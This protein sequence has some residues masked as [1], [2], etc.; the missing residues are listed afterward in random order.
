[1][2]APSA[3]QERVFRKRGAPA[4]FVPEPV[5]YR[6]A[7]RAK[8]LVDE[9]SAV[10]SKLVRRDEHSWLYEP[11]D[12]AR[13]ELYAPTQLAA[14]AAVVPPPLHF[15]TL[16]ERLGAGA[17]VD[18]AAFRADFLA[19]VD[20]AAE[21]NAPSTAVHSA[22]VRLRAY[23]L[24]ELARAEAR[25]VK[26]AQQQRDADERRRHARARAAQ[27]EAAAAADARAAAAAAR[28]SAA[29]GGGGVGGAA[30][31]AQALAQAQAQAR[32]RARGPPA[33]TG[34]GAPPTVRVLLGGMLFELTP[35][36]QLQPQPQLPARGGGAERAL[37]FV[38]L[39]ASAPLPAGAAPPRASPQL[40][41]PPLGS[42]APGSALWWVQAENCAHGRGRP[43]G[44]MPGDGSYSEYRTRMRLE[45]EAA[46]AGAAGAAL[47]ADAPAGGASGTHAPAADD[48]DGTAS[49]GPAPAQ[50]DALASLP[51]APPEWHPG[52]RHAIAREQ[53][54]ALPPAHLRCAA[55]KP[56][57]GEP[58]DGGLVPSS[59]PP[60]P[61][62]REPRAAGSSSAGGG[63]A[64]ATTSLGHVQSSLRPLYEDGRAPLYATRTLP[65][66]FE[67]PAARALDGAVEAECAAARRAWAGTGVRGC[68]LRAACALLHSTSLPRQVQWAER[69]LP[70]MRRART[71]CLTAVDG[72]RF[73][74]YLGS[75]R[76]ARTAGAGD[77]SA[78]PPR[79]HG[80][81]TA[82]G[83]RARAGAG[84]CDEG[85]EGSDDN[86]DVGA[87]AERV[88]A[89]EEWEEAL[90]AAGA[91]AAQLEDGTCGARGAPAHPPVYAIVT[92]Y[93]C[94]RP[95]LLLHGRCQLQCRLLGAESGADAAADT[96][97]VRVLW[98][99]GRVS[100]ERRA[101]FVP[102]TP[103]APRA[104]EPGVSGWAGNAAAA[105]LPAAPSVLSERP[106]ACSARKAPAQPP[107]PPTRTPR[108]V[109]AVAAAETWA[110]ALGALAADASVAAALGGAGA[111]RELVAD[112]Q[113][114]RA[115]WGFAAA[116]LE[117]GLPC[118]PSHSMASLSVSQRFSSRLPRW[119]AVGA[120]D[121]GDA[122]AACAGGSAQV[123]VAWLLA[124]LTGDAPPVGT[125]MLMPPHAHTPGATACPRVLAPC[126]ARD[127][128]EA[129]AAAAATPLAHSREHAA[130][131]RDLPSAHRAVGASL[132]RL[133][134]IGSDGGEPQRAGGPAQPPHSARPPSLKLLPPEL[135][136]LG[137]LSAKHARGV[138]L[139][140]ALRDAVAQRLRDALGADGA[141]RTALL[142]V[143]TGLPPPPGAPGAFRIDDLTHG[144]ACHRADHVPISAHNDRP[145]LA[146]GADGAR[147][148][149]ACEAE[150]EDGEKEEEEEEEEEEE[151]PPF[152]YL[153]ECDTLDLRDDAPPD[154]DGASGAESTNARASRTIHGSLSPT[155]R[156]PAESRPRAAL[157]VQMPAAAR[158]ANDAAAD[159]CAGGAG[160]A[161][162]VLC[163]PCSSPGDARRSP[164]DD[165]TRAPRARAAPRAP[166]ALRMAAE[167]LAGC[168]CTGD[169]ARSVH[170]ACAAAAPPPMPAAGAR[171]RGGAD[172]PP[173]PAEPPAAPGLCYSAAKR[174]VVPAG[175]PIYECN[176][177]CGCS[178][179]CANRV[180]QLGS[181]ARVSVFKTASKGW[182]LR[183]DER[184]RRGTFV[185][186]YTGE[187]VSN[188]EAER[189]GERYDA[190]GFSTLYDLDYGAA[191]G[192]LDEDGRPLVNVFT[193]DATYSCGVARFLNHS[194]EPNLHNYSVW[195]DNLDQAMP[196]IAFFAARDI[197]AGE[198]LTFD[199]KYEMREEDRANAVPC[200]CGA[201]S[202]R[203]ILY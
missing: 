2:A 37:A 129:P 103:P 13:P 148:D 26:R 51:P 139:L 198:E 72:G 66:L 82:S 181:R 100:R 47:P 185:C 98:A 15:C 179:E 144:R 30:L 24:D 73:A 111:L 192:A 176:S 191:A 4:P 154:A 23:G 99:S 156:A 46:L 145:A 68:G 170:C 6:N 101:R 95:V 120:E 3:A 10:L 20:G 159:A 48:A 87:D 107:A 195:V 183:A 182:A 114:E 109:A 132:A 142:A 85:W 136:A 29:D 50:A 80:A 89:C 12:P 21:R 117:A 193:I 152:H 76:R 63:M 190:I 40:H 75:Y 77:A 186:E 38:P 74:V 174:V 201:P 173:P 197:A 158:G 194:C 27:A 178:A 28:R 33:A 19:V 69:E 34:G 52:W 97:M 164:A 91:D 131:A 155:L 22:S 175:T 44:W 18:V 189:R 168:T 146:R 119:R 130:V 187:V 127:A 106:S 92:G 8:P 126:G 199:Y 67:R 134:A 137:R 83:S 56:H 122:Q 57:D 16:R 161:D 184:L 1:M 31:H 163:E 177:R 58:H 105:D 86:F 88:G 64:R 96:E 94:R 35:P 162:D 118:P 172:A 160:S 17:Y 108:G 115:R 54:R 128:A 71:P 124:L 61:A 171:E 78:P 104:L 90:D 143:V 11:F 102:P 41:P 43:F 121:E 9:L 55:G 7:P 125:A 39:P 25:A 153:H 14:R 147:G 116:R 180:L 81:A 93:H 65:W 59:R 151:L 36:P 84:A 133:A 167:F 5:A 157:A 110:G 62:P 53:A 138:W 200:Q 202:C 196:R 150:A 123:R 60:S 141:H 149:G 169:C 70:G 42:S 188:D 79:A 113:A 135:M 203:R 112:L 32:K 140:H 49:A 165:A 166:I 45:A